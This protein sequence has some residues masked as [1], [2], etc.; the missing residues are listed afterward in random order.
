[1][2][3]EDRL[4]LS[5]NDAM[6]MMS[7]SRRTFYGLINSGQLESLKIGAKRLI[8]KDGIEKYIRD[9]IKK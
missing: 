5:V 4:L 9:N 7:I 2:N 6:Y 3:E 8:P 1:M